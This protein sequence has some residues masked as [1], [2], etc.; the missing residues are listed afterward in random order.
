VGEDHTAKILHRD[1]AQPD[2]G[3][4]TYSSS[5]GIVLPDRARSRPS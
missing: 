1:H 4:R 5:S 3:Q 2:F